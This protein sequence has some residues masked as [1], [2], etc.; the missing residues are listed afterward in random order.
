M[1]ELSPRSASLEEAFMELTYDSVD[2]RPA[3]VS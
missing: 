2:Y 1:H 3:A